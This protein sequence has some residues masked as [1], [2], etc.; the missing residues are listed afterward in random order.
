VEPWL[1]SCFVVAM[2][3]GGITLLCA[4]GF[5]MAMLALDR[6]TKER[7][8]ARR[9]AKKDGKTGSKV[10]KDRRSP[11]ERGR[12]GT[13]V[14]AEEEETENDAEGGAANANANANAGPGGRRREKRATSFAAIVGGYDER[15]DEAVCCGPV[16]MRPWY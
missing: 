7:V 3:W 10:L 2:G 13:S 9:A 5:T 14:K 8:K 1:L 11:R 16:A 15:M 6:T 12:M 4:G